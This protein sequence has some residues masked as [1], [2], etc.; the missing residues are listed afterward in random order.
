MVVAFIPPTVLRRAGMIASGSMAP[1]ALLI[2]RSFLLIVRGP[3]VVAG[4]LGVIV[5][6]LLYAGFLW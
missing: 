1:G 5:S 3:G 6:G 4:D 2:V